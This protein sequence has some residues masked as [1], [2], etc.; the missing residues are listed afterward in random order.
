V[1]GEGLMNRRNHNT[2]VR[3]VSVSVFFCL[4]VQKSTSKMSE[5]LRATRTHMYLCTE[6]RN[7]KIVIWP[8]LSNRVSFLYPYLPVMAM[9][10]LESRSGGQDKAQ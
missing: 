5:K 6:Q 8:M 4:N 2:A 7:T 10:V 1:I 9:I 3:N